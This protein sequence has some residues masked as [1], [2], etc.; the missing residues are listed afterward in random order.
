MRTPKTI[1]LATWATFIIVSSLSATFQSGN[2][3]KARGQE[4]VLQENGNL[5]LRFFTPD[6]LNANSK[7]KETKKLDLGNINNFGTIRVAIDDARGKSFDTLVDFTISPSF[8]TDFVDVN[9]GNFSKND[10]LSFYVADGTSSSGTGTWG[11]DKAKLDIKNFDTNSSLNEWAVFSNSYVNSDIPVD[12]GFQVIGINQIITPP[13]SGQPLPGVF[14]SIL[15]GSA[16]LYLV[17]RRKTSAV[18]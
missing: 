9:I 13:P 3:V 4:L 11:G 5:T 14:A 10:K 8:G 18:A 2:Y 1:L 7:S 17:K 15:L 6:F 16:G 12:F